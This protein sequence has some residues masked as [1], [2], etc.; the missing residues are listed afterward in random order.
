[1]IND[2]GVLTYKGLTILQEFETFLVKTK[3]IVTNAVLGNDADEM[4]E[5]YRQYFPKKL[6]TGPGRQS[7][8]ELKQKFVWFFKNHPEFTWEDVLEAANYYS[9]EYA[10]KNNE[11]MTNS[12]NFIKKDTVSKESTSKLA[13]YCQIIID[14]INEEKKEN[15]TI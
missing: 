4:V 2:K 1:M 14:M 7:T 8:R 15:E 13:D 10:Q 3:K 6:A 5:K 11:Y 9:C 12:S